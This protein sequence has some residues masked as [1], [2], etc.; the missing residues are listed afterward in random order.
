MTAYASRIM[1]IKPSDKN[2]QLTVKQNINKHRKWDV[3]R[4]IFN[5][6]MGAVGILKSFY[7]NVWDFKYKTEIKDNVSFEQ[8][9]I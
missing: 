3:L 9:L 8:N 7:V 5:S 6:E 4:M 1:Q 2:F